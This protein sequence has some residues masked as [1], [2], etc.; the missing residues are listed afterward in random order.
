MLSCARSIFKKCSVTIL[1]YPA[2]SGL[3]VAG[4]DTAR[5]GRHEPRTDYWYVKE[6]RTCIVLDH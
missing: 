2:Q 1:S 4:C 3:T 6:M 5:S